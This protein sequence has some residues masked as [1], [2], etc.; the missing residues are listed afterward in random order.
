LHTTKAQV[1][2][3]DGSL[4]NLDLVNEIFIFQNKF[5]FEISLFYKNM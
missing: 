4:V 2:Q 1:A 5:M 3:Y